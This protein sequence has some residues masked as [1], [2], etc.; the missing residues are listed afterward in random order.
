MEMDRHRGVSAAMDPN[1][2]QLDEILATIDDPEAIAAIELA[3]AD[4]ERR[5][6]TLAAR[7]IQ[8]QVGYV[9]PDDDEVVGRF[10]VQAARRTMH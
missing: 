2:R 8:I 10:V 4:I 5:V 6:A 3:W 1:R 9:S 7:G